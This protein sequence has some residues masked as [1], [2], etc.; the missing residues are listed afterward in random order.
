MPNPYTPKKYD[1]KTTEKQTPMKDPWED[2][3]GLIHEVSNR[4]Y[5]DEEIEII[6]Q[7]LEDW[8]KANPKHPYVKRAERAWEQLYND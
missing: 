5:E 2:I 3:K 6:Q 4:S 7:Q 8:S 1:E